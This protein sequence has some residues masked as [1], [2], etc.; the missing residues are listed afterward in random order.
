MWGRHLTLQPSSEEPRAGGPGPRGGRC[1]PFDP[2]EERGRVYD[3]VVQSD[4][5]PYAR[6]RTRVLAVTC[7]T[8]YARA[9]I[10]MGKTGQQPRRYSGGRSERY[11]E[12]RAAR[13]VTRAYHRT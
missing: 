5:R 13:G 8:L 4:R 2:R 11:D 1:A 6:S 12:R 7:D 10:D 3:T 9:P